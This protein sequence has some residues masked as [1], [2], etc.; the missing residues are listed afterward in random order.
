[1]RIPEWEI[2]AV[3]GEKQKQISSR[4]NWETMIKIQ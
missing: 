3:N 1:L 2:I 4:K